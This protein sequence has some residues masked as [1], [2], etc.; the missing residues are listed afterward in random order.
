MPSLRKRVAVIPG[1]GVGVEVIS[2]ARRVVD[3]L[4]DIEWTEFPWGSSY[5]HETGLMMP[6]DGLALIGDCDAVLLGAVGDPSVPDAESLWGLTLRLRQGLDLWANIRPVRLLEGVPSVL[7]GRGPKDIDMVVVRENSEGEYSGAGGIAHRGYQH[8][9]GVEVSIFTRLG[10][11]RVVRYAF[12]LAAERSGRLVSATKSNA[13][14]YGYVLWD[15][16]VEEMAVEFPM[17]KTE[18]VLVD[19]L[20]AR[21]LRSPASLDVIVAS[22][23][24]GDILTDVGAA[25]QGGLGMAASA[26]LA[27]GSDSP[28]VFEPVHGSA[29]DIAGQGVA[30]PCGALW[31]AAMMLDY[32][33]FE[34]EADAIIPAIE[35]AV[36]RGP[37]TPDL[38][39]TASTE[40]FLEVVIDELG[41]RRA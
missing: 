41:K 4:S 2:A 6:D 8:E 36:M 25:L 34:Q 19:A 27:P 21:M 38:G 35:A 39:G 30:N 29:P 24:F 26:N 22:N 17:V 7:A 12:E 9:L 28:P 10:I 40:E 3:L 15:Q 20:A 32:L 31:S 5:R 13:S 18:H 14:R 37:T 23:L 16:V 1:D 33:G 11:E